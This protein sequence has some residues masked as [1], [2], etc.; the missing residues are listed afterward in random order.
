[1]YRKSKICVEY[2]SAL[3]QLICW[4]FSLPL[5]LCL[6]IPKVLQNLL[7]EGVNLSDSTG[8]LNSID[9][10]THAHTH[11]HTVR[12]N[13]GT[14]NLTDIICVSYSVC[15]CLNMHTC[16][17]KPN[18]TP[19]PSTSLAH[20]THKHTFSLQSTLFSSTGNDSNF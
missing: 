10:D 13:K 2:Q 8:K 11:T 5:A 12:T 20:A 7:S 16:P 19:L 14:W 3:R 6:H 1:M 18:E 4:I 15:V 9:F 17:M